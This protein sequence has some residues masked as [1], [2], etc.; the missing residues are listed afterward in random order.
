MP[1]LVSKSDIILGNEED[2]EKVFGIKPKNFNAEKIKDNI[3][4]EIFKDVCSQ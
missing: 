2:C 1:E 4:P 3:N